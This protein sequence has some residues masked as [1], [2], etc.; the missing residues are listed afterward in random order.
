M[1]HKQ[2]IVQPTNRYEA[3]A[4]SSKTNFSG[5]VTSGHT[6]KKKKIKN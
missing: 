2:S 3:I 4:T 6:L 5:S 1:H